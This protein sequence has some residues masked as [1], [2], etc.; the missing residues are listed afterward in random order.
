MLDYFYN[1]IRFYTKR[2]RK[3]RRIRNLNPLGTILGKLSNAAKR[4]N[5]GG[6]PDS[7]ILGKIDICAM[8]GEN[9]KQ[10]HPV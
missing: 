4:L 7:V 3:V 6:A 5:S 10:E 8:N 9:Q 1:N 2:Q